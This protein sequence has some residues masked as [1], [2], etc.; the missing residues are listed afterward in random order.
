MAAAN[1]DLF[2]V[3]KMVCPSA[4]ELSVIVNNIRCTQCGLI[5][6][7]ESRFRLHDLKVHQRKNLKK[8]VK[9]FV[10]YHCPESS[11]V[12]SPQSE[13]YFTTMKY[14]KQVWIFYICDSTIKLYLLITSNIIFFIYVFML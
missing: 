11:C 8:T 12:Y 5:F 9:E 1:S 3:I 2:Q 7:N 6:H 14:L 4:E 13:R 10:K